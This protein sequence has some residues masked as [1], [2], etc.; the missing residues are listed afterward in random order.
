MGWVRGTLQVPRDGEW[1]LSCEDTSLSATSSQQAAPAAASSLV[2]APLEDQRLMHDEPVMKE[3]GCKVAEPH[4]TIACQTISDATVIDSASVDTAVVCD[5]E[6][7][8]EA[9]VLP[10]AVQQLQAKGLDEFFKNRT[11]RKPTSVNLNTLSR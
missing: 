7:S 3:A 4:R 11:R 9:R 1:P 6:L 5:N 8:S 10:N 2:E